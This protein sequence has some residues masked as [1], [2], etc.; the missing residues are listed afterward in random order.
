LKILLQIQA[1]DLKIESCKQRETEIPKQKDKFNAQK[2]RLADELNEAEE[3]CK[4]IELAQREAE[5]ENEQKQAQIIKYE[6]QLMGV[7]KNEEYQALLHEIDGLKKQIN[8]NEEKILQ[9]MEEL[10]EAQAR[11]REDKDRIAA[12]QKRIDEQCAEIDAE[13]AEAVKVR[14]ALETEREPMTKDA[15]PELLGMYNRVRR[16]LTK[17]RALVPLNGES[18]GGCHMFVRPQII[19]EVLAGKVHACAHCNRLMYDKHTYESSSADASA[20]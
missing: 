8:Q 15:D 5:S 14:E 3:R 1:L 12:E 4:K 7:K 11:L 9:W 20:V 19:N 17:G 2:K 6:Q 16:R 10:E 13:L 18:C